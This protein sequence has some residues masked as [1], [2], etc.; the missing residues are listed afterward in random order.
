MEAKKR[1]LKKTEAQILEK[2]AAEPEGLP[3]YVILNLKVV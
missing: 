2:L 3:A 1:L